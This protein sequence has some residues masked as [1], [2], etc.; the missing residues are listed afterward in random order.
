M[1]GLEVQFVAYQSPG[2]SREHKQA[3][4][5]W[6]VNIITRVLNR[7]TSDKQGEF[8]VQNE[9]TA[10]LVFVRWNIATQTP[11]PGDHRVP[12]N[13][14]RTC[15]DVGRFLQTNYILETHEHSSKYQ[16]NNMIRTCTWNVNITNVS[17]CSAQEIRLR[18]P[19]P[20]TNV[21]LDGWRRT[22]QYFV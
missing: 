7:Q 20:S 4:S 8:S 22:L 11:V 15:L 18:R 12:S 5:S 1:R 14:W 10:I 2:K 21:K 19:R 3:I 16:V 17:V 13:Y 6:R 9:N